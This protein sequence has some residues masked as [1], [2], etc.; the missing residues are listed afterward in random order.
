[1]LRAAPASF[2]DPVRMRRGARTFPFIELADALSPSAYK[3]QQAAA[4]NVYAACSFFFCV[5]PLQGQNQ[6]VSYQPL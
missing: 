5:C 6:Q 3:Q 2:Q 1:M 4:K